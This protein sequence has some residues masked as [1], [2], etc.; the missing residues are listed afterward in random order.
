MKY[1]GYATTFFAIA[2]VNAVINGWAFSV[3]WGWFVASTFG[4]PTL[5][6]PVA[7]GLALT[8]GF[9][10]PMT[11]S[12]TGGKGFGELMIEAF[13]KVVMKSLLCVATGWLILQFV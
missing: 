5:T 7:I 12:D 10:L 8:I 4:L 13:I 9:L 6:I 2:F 3:L 11:D 1:I